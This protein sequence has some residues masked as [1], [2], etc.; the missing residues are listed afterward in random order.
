LGKRR[1][2]ECLR[3][4]QCCSGEGAIYF[5]VDQAPPAARELGLDLAEFLDRY[6]GPV[7]DRGYPVLCDQRGICRLLGP[8]GCLVHSCK[9]DICRR[10]P[11]FENILTRE[12]AFDEAK[13]ACP[14][15]D[16]EVSFLEF[17]AFGRAQLDEEKEP[18]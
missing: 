11:F 6:C 8:Q 3:C 18:S 17:A 15:I 1:P 5:S 7:E 10:W 13:L 9:P 14:G 16:P 2:F 4:S 12:S